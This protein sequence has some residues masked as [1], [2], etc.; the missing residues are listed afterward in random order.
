MLYHLR[1]HP[2]QIV[3]D[4]PRHELGRSQM[5]INDLGNVLLPDFVIPDSVRVDDQNRAVIAQP[6]ATTG[7]ELN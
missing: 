5:R 7:G 3:P 1:M 6:E 4:E 2:G